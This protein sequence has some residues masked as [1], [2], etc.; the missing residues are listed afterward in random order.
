M[1]VIENANKG[2]FQNVKVGDVFYYA[3][4]PYLKIESENDNSAINLRTF[5]EDEFEPNDEVRIVNAKLII[6]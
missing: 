2:F 6:E 1:E 3:G 4:I 5:W